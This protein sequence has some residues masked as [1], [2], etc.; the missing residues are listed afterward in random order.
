MHSYSGKKTWTFAAAFVYV[1]SLTGGIGGFYERIRQGIFFSFLHSY[2]FKMTKAS[3]MPLPSS[4][5]GRLMSIVSMFL[6]LPLFL[7]LELEI[8]NVI[9]VLFCWSVT[10]IDINRLKVGRLQERR[11]QDAFC[12]RSILVPVGIR[13]AGRGI[14]ELR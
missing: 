11:S 12:V 14:E 6:G 3:G 1:F 9:M 4:L 7:W 13:R 5:P 8:A 2:V 10:K